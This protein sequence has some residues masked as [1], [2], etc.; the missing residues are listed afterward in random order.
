MSIE[1]FCASF[2]AH[3]AGGNNAKEISAKDEKKN[4]SVSSVEVRNDSKA[5][6]EKAVSS[7]YDS[8]IQN[9]VEQKLSWWQKITSVFNKHSD[10]GKVNPDLTDLDKRS[11]VI[12]DLADAYMKNRS[13]QGDPLRAKSDFIE[14]VLSKFNSRTCKMEGGKTGEN[15]FRTDLTFKLLEREQVGNLL[16]RE[17][18]ELRAIERDR[19][20]SDVFDQILIEEFGKENVLAFWK[21]LKEDV[22]HRDIQ[23]YTEIQYGENEDVRS[24]NGK[25]YCDGEWIIHRSDKAPESVT[26]GEETEGVPWVKTT[27]FEVEVDYTGRK[28]DTL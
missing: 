21:H 23:L 14:L 1:S 26:T 5:A 19:E 9:K 6:Q 3:F 4:L 28:W 25:V 24:G 8:L 10:N 13:K 11:K 2:R 12:D 7:L 15:D 18:P 27:S 17:D 16:E 20:L 22:R